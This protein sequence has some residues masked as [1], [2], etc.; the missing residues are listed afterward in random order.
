MWNYFK[1]NIKYLYM[2]MMNN[3][4]LISLLAKVDFFKLSFIMNSYSIL[5]NL[6]A[7]I[8]HL[9]YVSKTKYFEYNSSKRN[10]PTQNETNI[11]ITALVL[12]RISQSKLDL[13]WF[14]TGICFCGK[15]S[16]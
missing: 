16:S 11:R 9:H 4:W 1:I 5:G 6:Y 2:Y 10:K 15:V 14:S 12:L 13:N 8:I 7:A 3:I